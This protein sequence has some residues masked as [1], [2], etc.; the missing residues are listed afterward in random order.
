MER[1]VGAWDRAARVVF[2]VAVIVMA[3]R[4]PRSTLWTALGL[5]AVHH[6]VSA[7]LAY[8]PFFAL[9]GVSSVPGAR[10]NWYEPLLARLTGRRRRRAVHLPGGVDVPLP[11]RT[12]RAPWRA[13]PFAARR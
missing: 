7:A 3:F 2:G 5:Y 4:R 8:D 10:N 1:N 6:L 9:A 13:I 12:E 11:W